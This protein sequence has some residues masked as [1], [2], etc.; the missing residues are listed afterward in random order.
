MNSKS[1]QMTAPVKNPAKPAAK[2]APKAQP[3]RFDEAAFLE[4]LKGLLAEGKN[5][6]ALSH[7]IEQMPALAQAK[8]VNRKEKL[9]HMLFAGRLLQSAGL[10][11]Y[12]HEKLL[13]KA[14]NLARITKKFGLRSRRT[15]V[16]LG[17][18]AHEPLGLATYFYLNG[19]DEAY[20]SDFLPVSDASYAALS[21]YDILSHMNMFP[22][23]YLMEGSDPELFQKR[24][25]EFDLDALS[26]GDWEKGLGHMA[27]KVEFKSCDIVEAGIP[28]NSVSFLISYAVF[29]H[30]M[31]VDGVTKHIF[32]IMEPGALGFH[33]IDLADHRAYRHDGEFNEF[34][35]LTEEKCAANLNRLRVSEQVAAFEAAGFEII[36]HHPKQIDVPAATRAAYLPRFAAMSEIDQ[37]SRAMRLVIR[38]PL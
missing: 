12:G 15:F 17:C 27:G 37:T 35:F 11:K 19:F 7:L 14:K 5:E 16:D 20:G 6:P 8:G 30:V 36:V 1:Q 9:K 21:M 31:D 25:R 13:G 22:E 28:S 24:I 18:G 29:E 34:S 26:Q 33:Y 38:K 2:T 23:R 10:G 32:D 4:Q 3:P